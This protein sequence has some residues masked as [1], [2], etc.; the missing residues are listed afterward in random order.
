RWWRVAGAWRF[1][2]S[3]GGQS[4]GG[5]SGDGY[6]AG[7]GDDD[8]AGCCC[9][10]LGAYSGMATGAGRVSGRCGFVYRP[11][12]VLSLRPAGF[13]RH[14]SVCRRVVY[15]VDALWQS[16]RPA[17]LRALGSNLISF[18]RFRPFWRAGA[19]CHKPEPDAQNPAVCKFAWWQYWHAPAFPAP[20]ANPAL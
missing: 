18:Y 14:Y 12:H 15:S 4:G 7:G 19:P 16:A 20:R 6:A 9:A 17:A 11:G 3:A 10:L 2:G 13:Q 8:A 1:S 5:L